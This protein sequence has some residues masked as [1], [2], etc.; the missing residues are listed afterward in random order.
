MP[1]VHIAEAVFAQ[2]IEQTGGYSEAKEEIKQ[3]VREGV[4]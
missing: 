1:A 4:E 2:Y 3:V